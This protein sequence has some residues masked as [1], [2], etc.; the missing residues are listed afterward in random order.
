M[1]DGVMH[2]ESFGECSKAEARAKLDEAMFPYRARSKVDRMQG[3]V[4]RMQ[5]REAEIARWEEKSPAMTIAEAYDIYERDPSAPD[6]G[7]T[8]RARYRSQFGRLER[9]MAGKYPTVKELRGITRQMAFE[10]LEDLA[11]KLSA[12]SYNKHIT[13]F[14]RIWKVLKT[15]A[16]LVENPW[17]E[18]RRKRIEASVRRELSEEELR[19]IGEVVE[20][21]DRILFKVGVYTGLRLG[22]AVRLKWEDIDFKKNHIKLEPSK[23]RRYTRGSK[24]IIPLV[25]MLREELMRVRRGA[26]KGLVMPDLA[27]ICEK[28]EAALSDRLKKIFQSVGIETTD[29]SSGKRGRC[30]VGFHSLRH[31]FVS[32]AAEAGIPFA[33]VQ[34]IVGHTS[35]AM[36]Q[37]YLHISERALQEHVKAFPAVFSGEAKEEHQGREGKLTVEQVVEAIE[38]MGDE[39]RATVIAALLRKK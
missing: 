23:T 4:A 37:H 27:A 38:R 32:I 2:Y 20:G 39:E 29:Y 15:R 9:W 34:A 10:F 7:E 6:S 16:R 18:A 12:N 11:G 13:T 35:P 1:S 3:V 33:T 14:T 24:I 26:K 5:G 25:K 30:V 36:T 19:K 28:D 21:E 17:T 22:D 31:T 8:T